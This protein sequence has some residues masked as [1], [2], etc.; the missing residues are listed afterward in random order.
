MASGFATA[1]IVGTASFLPVFENTLSVP[2]ASMTTAACMGISLLLSYFASQVSSPNP[3][4]ILFYELMG[5]LLFAVGLVVSN[6]TKISATIAFLDLS[7]FNPALM[8]VMGGAIFVTLPAFYFIL[9]RN[10]PLL[11][12]T[13]SLPKANDIDYS[14]VFGAV[15]FGSG[16]GLVG[17][18]PG[19]ALANIGGNL[20]FQQALYMTFLIVG[21]WT[22]QQVV[23]RFRV[24]GDE[25]SYKQ[26]PSV[27]VK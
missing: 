22:K 9:K 15:F 19:P 17:A 10:E 25:G 21:V 3:V 8:F 23:D 4:L 2:F 16:W 12:T 14:L 1:T 24:D 13:W 11:G 27:V 18:C 20:E 26:I 5:G 7:V 6:M